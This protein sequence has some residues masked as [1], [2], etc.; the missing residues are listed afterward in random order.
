[1]N[2][3]FKRKWVKALR[4]GR[5]EQGQS[6]LKQ[7]DRFCCLGVLCQITNARNWNSHAMPT[8]SQLKRFG[9]DN[10]VSLTLASMNDAGS[11]FKQ[12]AKYIETKDL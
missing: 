4:S 1:M 5:Y 3:T 9:L 8:S 12:I 10:D 11:T 6:C 2:K 7:G